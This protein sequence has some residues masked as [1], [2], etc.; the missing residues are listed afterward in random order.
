MDE[1]GSAV[2]FRHDPVTV[3]GGVFCKEPLITLGRR[4][5]TVIRSQETCLFGREYL[6]R[7]E[8]QVSFC[9]IRIYP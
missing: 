8:G 6:V 7:E 1:K 5:K 3:K 4:K 9:I 2:R